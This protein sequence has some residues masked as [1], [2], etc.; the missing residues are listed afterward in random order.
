VTYGQL[1]IAALYDPTAFRAFWR[2][3][4]MIRRPDEEYTDPQIVG[5]THETL[6][7]HG[8]GPP[9]VQPSREELLAALNTRVQ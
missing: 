3:M 4:G 7:E 9:I 6:R 1:R 5:R 2:I 8:S